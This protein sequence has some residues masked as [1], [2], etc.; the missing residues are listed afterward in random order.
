VRLPDLRVV[1]FLQRRATELTQHRIARPVTLQALMGRIRVVLPE[2]SL[3]L[4]AGALMMVG[5]SVAYSI[6]AVTDSAFLLSMP[7]SSRAE[8]HPS[9]PVARLLR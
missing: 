6:D 3:E 8:A 7:W 9:P 2:G 1:L 5:S 4:T